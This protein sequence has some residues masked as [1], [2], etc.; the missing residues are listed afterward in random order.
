MASQKRKAETQ[1]DVDVDMKPQSKD[2]YYSLR[3]TPNYVQLLSNSKR[4]SPNSEED[5]EKFLGKYINMTRLLYELLKFD[6]LK[7]YEE[8][9]RVKKQLRN[10]MK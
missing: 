6:E 2:E 8:D 7:I 3:K 5:L 9:L 10:T 1:A 4:D